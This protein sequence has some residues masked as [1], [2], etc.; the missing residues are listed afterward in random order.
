MSSENDSQPARTQNRG[1]AE[2]PLGNDTI[3]EVRDLSVTFDME[4]GTSRVLDSVDLDVYRGEILGV[5]GESGSGKSMLADSMLNAVVDPGRATGSVTYYTEDGSSED[6]L[7]LSTNQLSRVRWEMISMVFQGALSS[8]NP[9]M[10]IGPHFRETLSAHGV[11]EQAGM[12]RARTL[13]SDLYL[14]PD[15]ILNSYPHELSGGMKQRAL[16]ALSLLLEPDVLV[17]DEPT[18]ALDLLMQRSIIALLGELQTKYDLTIVFITHDLELVASLADRIAV[19]YAFEVVEIGT[20]RDII[21]DSNHPYTRAL[22]NSTPNLETPVDRMRPIEGESPDP[23][24]VPEGC[25]YRTRCPLSDEFCS[26]EDPELVQIDDDASVACHYWERVDEEVPLT[27]EG[28]EPSETSSVEGTHSPTDRRR[29]NDY[30][31]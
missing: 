2:A 1:T 18:A 4:R 29:S 24:N 22:I 9:T 8:F 10:E 13:L 3:L 15:R 27:I 28:V 6:V 12:D 30:T 26:A 17:M 16:I 5:V 23:V 19:L 21:L 20:V 14:E 11:D 25:S 7:D 31:R